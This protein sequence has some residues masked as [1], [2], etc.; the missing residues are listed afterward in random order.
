MNTITN[1]CFVILMSSL[2]IGGIIKL[3]LAN[4]I[5]PIKIN[6]FDKLKKVLNISIG[7]LLLLFTEI[8]DEHDLRTLI[9][10]KYGLILSHNEAKSIIKSYLFDI[11]S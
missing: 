9:K 3:S 7:E 4:L 11:C 6:S 10:T 5:P 8:A 2:F 1:W